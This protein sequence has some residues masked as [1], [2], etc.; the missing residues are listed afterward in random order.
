MEG[1]PHTEATNEGTKGTRPFVFLF[2]TKSGYVYL[3]LAK[4]SN[5]SRAELDRVPYAPFLL[6]LR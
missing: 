6:Y 1:A 4:S 2:L 5:I 3:D